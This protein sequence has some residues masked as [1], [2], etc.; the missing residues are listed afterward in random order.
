LLNTIQARGDISVDERIKAYRANV[1]GAHLNALDQVFQVIREVLG[2][3][4]WRQLLE[5]EIEAFAS[6]SPDLHTYGEFVPSLLQTAQ[7]SRPELKDF[8]YLRDLATLEWHAHCA[9][10]ALDDPQFNWKAFSALDPDLQSRVILRP[11][12]ALKVFHSRYPV[13]II[14]HAHQ[15]TAAAAP[16][17]GLPAPICI[18]RVNRFDVT[19]TRLSLENANLLEAIANGIS[20]DE[21]YDQEKLRQSEAIVRQLY[22]WI[23]RGWIVAFEVR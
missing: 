22:D 13:D 4:Y 7:E 15:A 16:E 19:V 12:R 10:F 18:H 11:G 17:S 23:Q 5:E 9:R 2:A 8:P 3:R 6:T 1:R 14:W 21:L 20:L